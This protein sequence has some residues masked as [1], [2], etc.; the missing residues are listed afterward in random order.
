MLASLPNLKG[1]DLKNTHVTDLGIRR[2]ES[3]KPGI[4]IRY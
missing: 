1:V 4:G 2:L 3:L